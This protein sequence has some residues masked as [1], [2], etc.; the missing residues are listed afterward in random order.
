ML[1]VIGRHRV[2][3]ESFYRLTE[4]QKA[5][6]EELR[7]MNFPSVESIKDIE[8]E[9]SDIGM[10]ALSSAISIRL[11][12]HL[13]ISR[14]VELIRNNLATAAIVHFSMS[15]HLLEKKPD[16]LYLMNGRLAEIRP[17]MRVAEKFGVRAQIYERTT[18]QDRYTCFN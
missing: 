7:R 3:S 15:H 17:A 2:R 5:K 6:V 4:E 13:S 1:G 14:D 11:D 9:G 16:M 12:P 18:R 8:L 10:A